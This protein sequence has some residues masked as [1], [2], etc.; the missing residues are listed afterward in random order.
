MQLETADFAPG[1]AT[2]R[3]GRNIRVIFESSP[4]A[5]FRENMTSSAKPEVDNVKGGP[6]HGH[7]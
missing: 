2:C 1:T 3:T 7:S 4:F 6:S 5:P